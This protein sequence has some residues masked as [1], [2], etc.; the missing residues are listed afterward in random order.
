[1]ATIPFNAVAANAELILEYCEEDLNLTPEATAKAAA[2]VL[3][4][5]TKD[6]GLAQSILTQVCNDADDPSM[7][8]RPN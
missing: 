8:M 5:L 1:M 6:S 2:I 4:S 7:I 3:R